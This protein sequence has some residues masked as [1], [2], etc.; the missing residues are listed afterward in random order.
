MQR[1][2]KRNASQVTVVTALGG[3]DYEDD[4]EVIHCQG[5]LDKGMF[6]HMVRKGPI[7]QPARLTMEAVAALES[8]SPAKMR[9]DACART[10]LTEMKSYQNTKRDE[11]VRYESGKKK[12]ERERHED[13]EARYMA[14][15][16]WMNEKRNMLRR[17]EEK[18]MQERMEADKKHD[19]GDTEQRSRKR[20]RES[21]PAPVE[22]QTGGPRQDPADCV[23]YRD[24]IIKDLLQK[25]KVYMTGDY[26]NKMSHITNKNRE[27]AIDW[28][29][30]LH[31]KYRMKPETLYGCVFLLDRFLVQKLDML[32][33][34][35][36][37]Y[38]TAC[39]LIAAKFEEVDAVP[40]V[41][42]LVQFMGIF[43]EEAADAADFLRE[44]EIE[45][46]EVLDF[47]FN[48]PSPYQFL[49]NFTRAAGLPSDGIH[50]FLA[51]FFLDCT[52]LDMQF[53]QMLP[54]QRAAVSLFLAG[55]KL[56]SPIP[57]AK[58]G[59]VFNMPVDKVRYWS[60]C[61][62]KWFHRYESHAVFR[63]YRRPEYLNVVAYAKH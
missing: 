53:L 18:K 29:M 36:Q 50:F 31:F 63:K 34:E 4:C 43:G 22:A 12:Q 33:E 15:K 10:G 58:W 7:M 23:D 19:R 39:F 55:Q 27:R 21:C 3:H 41:D 5:S 52:L 37:T 51:M 2:L 57:D 54:S 62:E 48:V 35:F 1:T 28:I 45:V 60:G 8:N 11:Q 44:A 32:V 14:N 6:T 59:A 24:A 16:R 20:R 38:V 42:I 26:E 61:V 25:Q 40:Q 46:L 49:L 56:K 17:I 13:K 30:E 47:K 9:L